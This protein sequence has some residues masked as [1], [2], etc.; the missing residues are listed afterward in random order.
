[1]VSLLIDLPGGHSAIFTVK[2]NCPYTIWPATLTGSGAAPTTGFELASQASRTINIASPWSG[3]F[4]ARFQCSSRGGKFLCHSGDCG[5]GKIS[6][7]GRGGIPPATLAEFTLGGADRKDFFDISLVDG[8]NLPVLV[9]PDGRC[10]STACPVDINRGCRNELAVRDRHGGIIERKSACVAFNQPQ[11]CCT[12][13]YASP[14]TCK[15]T[16][17]SQIFKR[18]YPQAYSYAYNDASSTFTCPTGV[19][20]QI[21]FCP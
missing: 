15:P 9:K 10:S 17:Y 14:K 4:W 20:Y 16:K 12:G 6:C 1:M 2:N 21:T 18:Q 3:R 8:F 7:N 13:S 11:Y 5:S 19:N